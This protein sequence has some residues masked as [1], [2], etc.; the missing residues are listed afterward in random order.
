MRGWIGHEP[1]IGKNQAYPNLIIPIL[2]SG[3]ASAIMAAGDWNILWWKDFGILFVIVPAITNLFFLF[4]SNEIRKS[5]AFKFFIALISVASSYSAVMYKNE[6]NLKPVGVYRTAILEKG[7]EEKE[8]LSFHR[9]KLLP[10]EF[11]SY[12]YNDNV[13]LKV[14]RKH[15]PGDRLTVNV[16]KGLLNIGVYNYEE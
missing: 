9:L 1:G 13:P 2:G 14:F 11:I 5:F 4:C 6:L 8:I 10:W 16:Q 3:I 15:E 12:E 7:V